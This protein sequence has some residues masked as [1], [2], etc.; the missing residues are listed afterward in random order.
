MANPWM[1]LWLSAANSWAGAVRASAQRRCV[2]SRRPWQTNGSPNDRLLGQNM[3]GPDL[4]P[5]PKGR[6]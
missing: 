2:A 3:H 5:K 1:S 4:R 6:R